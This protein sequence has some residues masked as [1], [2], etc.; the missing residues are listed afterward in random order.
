MTSIVLTYKQNSM[1]QSFTKAFARNFEFIIAKRM[2]D[3]DFIRMHCGL[4]SFKKTNLCLLKNRQKTL[5]YFHTCVLTWHSIFSKEANLSTST[6]RNEAV[7]RNAGIV[8]R[9]YKG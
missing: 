8:K 2:D 4:K 9:S 5:G 3:V 6:Q 7:C 1:F